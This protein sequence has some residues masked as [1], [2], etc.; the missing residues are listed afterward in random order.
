MRA[1]LAILCIALIAMPAMAAKPAIDARTMPEGWTPLPDGSRLTGE[2]LSE[3]FEGAFPPAGWSETETAPAPYNWS[4]DPLSPH[5]G[6]YE[7][8][9]NWNDVYAQDEVLQFGPIDL[10]A[11]SP[12]DLNL[13]FWLSGSPYWSPNGNTEVYVSSDGSSW[14]LVWD[15]V[16]DLVNTFTWDEFNIDISAYAGGN[17]YAKFRYVGLDGA[18]VY[19]DDVS[20][21]YNTPPVAPDNDTCAGAEANGYFITPLVPFNLTGNNTLANNDY[22]LSFSSCTGYSALGNDVVWVVDMEDGWNLSVTMTTTGWD[23]SIYLI[24]DCSDPH[25][26]CVAGADDYPD[27][28]SFNYTHTGAPGRYYLIVS[29]YGSGTGDFTVTGLLDAPVSVEASSWGQVKGL[30]R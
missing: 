21:G 23:D 14:T 4:Q 16:S 18:D 27:G 24:T 20:V 22:P 19:L 9:I 8:R 5:S 13:T 17:F 15:A 12:T 7:A 30:Y 11:A 25:N 26:S 6:A 10:S 3:G 2:F 28:S 29:A 1:F